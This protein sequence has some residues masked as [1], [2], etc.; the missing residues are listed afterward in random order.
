MFRSPGRSALFVLG[1][2]LVAGWA[3]SGRYLYQSFIGLDPS[4]FP[5]GPTVQKIVLVFAPELTRTVGGVVLALGSLLLVALLG[6]ALVRGAL[7]AR[8]AEVDPG[9]RRFLTGAG[10]G[11][12]VAL[13][14]LAVGGVAAAGRA[15]YGIGQPD[16]DEEGPDEEPLHSGRIL[17]QRQ[18]KT[19]PR[20]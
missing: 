14:S 3:V 11:A 8:A 18:K 13:G 17:S 10:S 15:L 2:A 5:L 19:N 1:L 12:G 7:R 16:V 9:R 4:A 20:K 6:F